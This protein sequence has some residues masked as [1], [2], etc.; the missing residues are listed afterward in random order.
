MDLWGNVWASGVSMGQLGDVWASGGD[1][2]VIY[3]WARGV[4]YVQ[5]G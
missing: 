2:W 4:M 5:V 3:I 1:V